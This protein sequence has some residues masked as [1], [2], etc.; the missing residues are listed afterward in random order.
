[1][2]IEINAT[3]NSSQRLPDVGYENRSPAFTMLN[4]QISKDI[5]AFGQIYVGIQNALNV[6]QLNPVVGGDLPF[7]G[8]FDA[9]VVWGPIMGRQIYAGWRYDLKFQE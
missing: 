1:M 3:Y 9:S 6:R 5:P 7:D 2:G 4:G 8:R